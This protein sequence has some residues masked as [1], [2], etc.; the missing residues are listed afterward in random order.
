[1][2]ERCCKKANIHIKALTA[3]GRRRQASKVRQNPTCKLTEESGL[4]FAETARLLGV[5]T[6]AAAK[7]KIRMIISHNTL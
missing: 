4:S 1:M 5:S 3:G 2:I 7:I 6:S